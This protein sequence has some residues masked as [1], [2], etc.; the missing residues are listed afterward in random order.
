M[1]FDEYDVNV[2]LF[3]QLSNEKQLSLMSLVKSGKLSIDQALIQAKRDT[4]RN[5]HS[6]VNNLQYT[7]AR[8]ER[9]KRISCLFLCR[10]YQHLSVFETLCA[11]MLFFNTVFV[12]NGCVCERRTEDIF[13]IAI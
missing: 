6:Q 1:R 7:T 10:F 13:V 11:R 9:S 5:V 4:M 12:Q 2:V 8:K 3:L